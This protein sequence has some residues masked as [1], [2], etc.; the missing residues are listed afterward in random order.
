[1]RTD[2]GAWRCQRGPQ[3]AR[4]GRAG[5]RP[6]LERRSGRRHD[7]GRRV[8]ARRRHR[9]GRP[10]VQHLRQPARPGDAGAVPVGALRGLLG[11]DQEHRALPTPRQPPELHRTAT[12]GCTKIGDVYAHAAVIGANLDPISGDAPGETPY[13]A[14]IFLH[15]H[16]YSSSGAHEGDQRLRVAGDGRPRRH[17]A[18]ASTR[19]LTRTSRSARPPG[20]APPP[21]PTSDTALAL[22]GMPADVLAATLIAPGRLELRHYPYPDQLE[23]GAV[24]LR[25]LASGICG[26]DKHTFRGETQQYAGTDHASS[27]PFPIIQGHE[28][29]GVVAAIGDGRGAGLRRHAAE[30]RRPRRPGAEPGVR[31]VRVLPRRLP[32]L[33]LPA[34]RELRQLA[35]VAPS[36]RTC[37]AAGPST[38]TSGRARRCSRCPTSCRPRWRC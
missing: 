35:V 34:A 29:V 30:R 7:A 4:F 21:E 27:T 23:P 6:L 18:A 33:L 12:S 13:A 2:D 37:S 1:M 3:P 32:V 31:R 19:A 17:A 10:D 24:L 5:T 8:P 16:S 28:N 22:P 26:T 38:S 11:R 36:R 9:V 25:M 15:R 14:A 20:C